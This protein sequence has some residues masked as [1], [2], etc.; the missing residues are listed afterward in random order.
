MRGFIKK[1]FSVQQN[2]TVIVNVVGAFVVKGGSLLI[3]VALFP[4]YIDLFKDQA[5]LGIWYT[6]LSVLNWITLFDLGLGQGLRNQL[7]RVLYKRDMN[8]AKEYISTTYIVMTIVSIIVLC[9]GMILI[10][11]LNLYSVFNIDSNIVDYAGL[12]KSVM[13]VF[14]GIIIQMVL[15]IVTSI[16]YAMQ[17]SAIVN[18]LGLISNI[19]ILIM[20]M[21]I[22]S[23]TIEENLVTMSW[24]N[25][26]A[27][28]VPYIVCTFVLFCTVLKDAAPS[29]LSYRKKCVKGIFN[30]GLA[31]LWLQIVFMVVS[32]ANEILITILT[33]PKYVVEYQ[34]YYKLFNTAAMLVSLALTPIWS[35]VTKAQ[36]EKNY[37]WIKKVYCLFLGISVLCFIVELCVIPILQWVMDLWLGNG[38]IS[39]SLVNAFI[40]A[41]SSVTFVL[42]NVNTSIGNGVSYFRLQMIWMTVAAVL[43]IPLA[44]MLV[45]IFGSWIGVVL[46]SVI[47]MAPY[48]IIA[49]VYTMKFLRKRS[50]FT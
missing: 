47:A 35:A 18:F 7:P 36:V 17:K 50:E 8:L 12:Q 6:I 1:L 11:N 40:F 22:P 24:I 37:G 48:E 29:F 3:S 39:V 10:P 4:L 31:L 41:L 16:L 27:A 23:R 38:T 30:I 20:L 13:I 9:F 28:N 14:G 15:K 43:F 33:E 34:A 42:H 19:I 46:A 5:I 21:I 44:W 49:P 2:R 25:V 32:S 26:L 45:H